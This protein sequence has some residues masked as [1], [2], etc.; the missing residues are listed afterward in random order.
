MFSPCTN[1]FS[2]KEHSQ[3]LSLEEGVFSKIKDDNKTGLSVED[4]EFLNMMENG[5]KKDPCGN[6]DAP[7]SFRPCKPNLS[8]NRSHALT[9]ASLLHASFYRTQQNEITLSVLCSRYLRWVMSK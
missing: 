5:M 7:L 1:N 4:R 8:N 9:R 3:S 2:I 6:W